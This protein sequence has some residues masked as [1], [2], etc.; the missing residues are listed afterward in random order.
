MKKKPI[1]YAIAGIPT[2]GKTTFITSAIKYGELPNNIFMH[3]SDAELVGLLGYQADLKLLG[4][5]KAFANWE[6]TAIQMAEDKLW[7]AVEAGMDIIYD[8][9]C[10]IPS[11]L[12]FL[13]KLVQ[14]Y[15]YKLI[16]YILVID[17]KIALQRAIERE[18]TKMIHTPPD[19]IIDKD[20]RLTSNFS[21]YCRLASTLHVLDS[22]IE[23]THK[24]QSYENGVNI[25]A[26]S[27]PSPPPTKLLKKIAPKL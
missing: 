25:Y 27:D 16:M 11:S 10:A 5:A 6:A 1:I 24:I 22:S 9:S 3:N 23:P 14:E 8:R 12:P 20:Q 15:N 2:A 4:P 7:R 18:Q 13:Q 17:P 21:E 19:A 26:N